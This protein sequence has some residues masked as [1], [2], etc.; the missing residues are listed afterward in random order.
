[1]SD[2]TGASPDRG[3]LGRPPALRR[4][5]PRLLR[6]SPH[7]HPVHRPTGLVFQLGGGA[8]RPPL[9]RCEGGVG[10]LLAVR[11]TGAPRPRTARARALGRSGGGQARGGRQ[12]SSRKRPS[13]SRKPKRRRARR[14]MRSPNPCKRMRD[15]L[16][17]AAQGVLLEADRV[18]GGATTLLVVGLVSF[19]GLR[20]AAGF[21]A[22]ARY[23]ETVHP[24]AH[25]QEGPLRSESRQR[26]RRR[27]SRPLHVSADPLPLYRF[28]APSRGSRG[29]PSAPITTRRSPPCWRSGSTALRRP[30]RASSTGSRRRCRASSGCSSSSLPGRPGRW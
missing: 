14:A 16:I 13:C 18:E 3:S 21:F 1:M 5:Q 22:N 24:L 8:G 28:E 25:R 23:E 12:G 7:P 20:A 10:I 27:P 6:R 26:A 15:N 30:V 19:L 2:A 29:S 11:D 9:G 17:R 4:G